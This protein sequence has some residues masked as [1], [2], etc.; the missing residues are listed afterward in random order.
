V[1]RD[2]SFHQRS[3][4]RS[5]G[6]GGSPQY[7]HAKQPRVG[8][9]HSPSDSSRPLILSQILGENLLFVFSIDDHVLEARHWMFRIDDDDV[10]RGEPK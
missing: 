4:L 7:T 9:E 8:D 5:D 2:S 3:T 10:L 6:R 1:I